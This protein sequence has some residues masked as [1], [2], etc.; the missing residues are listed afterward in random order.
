MLLVVKEDPITTI[1]NSL[2]SKFDYDSLSISVQDKES[3]KIF[4]KE[5]LYQKGRMIESALITGEYLEKA[6]EL[7]NRYGEENNSYMAWYQAL[8]FLRIKCIY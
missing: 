1:V 4:E 5:V 2:E 7:F 8:G 3:L 6:R